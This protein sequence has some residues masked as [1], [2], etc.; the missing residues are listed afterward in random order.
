MATVLLAAAGSAVGAGFGGTV[1]GL[2]GAVIGRAV[3]ATLGRVID[4]RLMGAG[5]AAVETGRVERF[6]VSGASEGATI[7]RVWGR[8]RVAGQVIWASRFEETQA[9]SGGGKGAPKPVTVEYSYSV[10]LALA[11]C[12]GRITRVGRIWADGIEIVP[13]D[14]NMRVYKG[15]E[16]QLPD[17]KIEAVEGA[18]LVPAYRGV[19][20][21]VIEDLDLGRFGNRVPQLSFE[22]FRRAAPDDDAQGGIEPG[23][24]IRGVALI[25]GS[26]EYALATVPVRFEDGPGAYRMANVHS[27]SGSTDMLASMKQL[28]E[29]LPNC[30]SGAL[31]VSWFGD[32][33]RCGSCKIRPKVEQNTQD[34]VPVAWRVAGIG[35]ASAPVMPKLD[36]RPVYG[37]TPADGSVIQ[38][39]AAMRERGIGCVFYPFVLMDQLAGNTRSDPYSGAAEQ[40]ALPWRGRITLSVAPGR[41]GTPDRTSA[42]DAEV[43]AFFG[44]AQPGHFQI[45]GTVVSYSGPTNDWGYRRFILHNAYLAK[46]AG[47]VDAFCIGSEMRGLTQI[48]GAGDVFLAVAALRQLAADVR[49][50][51]G[52]ETR[53]GYAA[54]WSEYFGYNDGAGNRYFHLDPLW[55]DDNIDFIGVDNYMPLADW[56]DADDHADAHWGSIYNLDYLKSNIAGGQ[57][58]DWY[59]ASDE[60]AAEQIRT[61]ITDGAYG[62]PWVWRYKDLRGW[63]E[64][65]HH[66]RIDGIRQPGAT[67]WVPRSKPIWF[68]EYGCAAVNKGANQPNMFFDPK[69]SESGAPKYSNGLRDDLMQMQ[70]LRAMLEYWGS[71]ANNPVSSDYG[72]PMVDMSRA[73]VWAWDTRPFPQFPNAL[74]V[75]SDGVNHARGHWI[76]GRV[77]VQSLA[78][79]VAEICNRSGLSDIDVSGLYGVVRGFAAGDADT[80]RKALQPLMLAYGFEALER[81]GQVLFRMRAGRATAHVEPGE[82]VPDEE[83]GGDLLVERSPAAEIAGR[84]R[85]LHVESNGDYEL[86]AVEAAFPDDDRDAVSQSEFDLVLTRAEGLRIVER[87][88]AE[89]LVARDAARFSLPPSRLDLGPG[90]V[91]TIGEGRSSYRIDAVELAEFQRLDAIRVEPSVYVPSDAAEAPVAP[92]P[93]T[94]PMPVFPLFLDLP[95][96]TEEEVPQA[97]R[98]AVTATPWPGN[99]AVYA[100]V[101]D[102]GY[103]LNRLVPR[104]AVIGVTETAM[105]RGIPGLWDRGRALRVRIFGGTLATVSADAVLNG[106]NVAAIGNGGAEGW[107]VFQFAQAILVGPDTYELSMRLRGQA[108]TDAD[109]AVAWPSGSYVVLLNGAVTQISLGL[110][111]R[112]L[113]RYYR[114]GSAFRT[115]DDPS[116]VHRVEAFRGIGLRPYAPAHLRAQR[117]GSGDIHIGWVRRTRIDGDSWE[118][119]EVPLGEAR[120]AYLLRVWKSGSILR[121]LQLAEAGWTYPAA[122]QAADGAS[123]AISL[124]VAQISDRFGP[125]PFARIDWNV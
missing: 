1:F 46:A 15:S 18:G 33:L 58:F 74:S 90:D 80:A 76:S 37:G 105:D 88:L 122:L 108:G 12:E 69:S 91:V 14:L 38:A 3:G 75:W 66:E 92:R 17:P 44:G 71:A 47:G 5:S 106:A 65:P 117:S 32:D 112:G 9:E 103:T 29:E 55:A 121:E 78:A 101:Q 27:P 96:L 79:V 124:L 48:R 8:T 4:Q 93:F 63:W 28:R 61:P 113:A 85:L 21:V 97:P 2:S 20:Y 120:E 54:D 42:A 87:W 19:A 115:Y 119:I 73:H 57:G 123:G 35:R 25:P 111:E 72:G 31:V 83:K 94:P 114:I 104:G 125:G 36:G 116:Y 52:P 64:N 95:L 107:E 11:L 59:Y 109:M 84:V 39:I 16:N 30:T 89:S 7:G 100:S 6:R 62:E 23:Q 102:A 70:Y 34:G 98:I 53:I 24:A 40:P 43:A 41:V 118:G 110:S 22:V 99:V 56:R 68:T 26:G 45:S 10:S 77:S 82:L 86:S 13:G 49:E 67:S 50:V 60:A 51:L 81:E